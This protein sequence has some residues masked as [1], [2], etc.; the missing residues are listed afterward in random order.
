MFLL[1]VVSFFYF[2][3]WVFFGFFVAA[4]S[5]VCLFIGPLWVQYVAYTDGII[6]SH[7]MQS[8]AVVGSLAGEVH[9]PLLCHICHAQHPSHV[10]IAQTGWDRIPGVGRDWQTDGL[11]SMRSETPS[12]RVLGF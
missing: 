9:E 2:F 4:Y 10:I 8:L 1:L 11:R 7:S 3:F 12:G 5:L 6:R